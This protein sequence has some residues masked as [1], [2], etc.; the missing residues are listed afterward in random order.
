MTWRCPWPPARRTA[1]ARACLSPASSARYARTTA[2]FL[3]GRVRLPL[4]G[5]LPWTATILLHHQLLVYMSPPAAW[6]PSPRCATPLTGGG[7][8]VSGQ[9]CRVTFLRI[10][11]LIPLPRSRLQFLRVPNQLLALRLRLLLCNCHPSRRATQT[12]SPQQLMAPW[13]GRLTQSLVL[14]LLC[15]I[16]RQPG[17]LLRRSGV[18]HMSWRRLPKLRQVRNLTLCRRCRWGRWE[19]RQHWQLVF[20][21]PHPRPC[22]LAA[23]LLPWAPAHSSL[24][25]PAGHSQSHG[26]PL[27]AWWPRL[28]L[29]CACS[30]EL[31]SLS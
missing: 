12:R 16:C 11:R 23:R 24:L 5:G 15:C 13:G 3:T 29:R 8:M 26:P 1:R 4:R 31:Q 2:G 6:L 20:Q 19:G 27:P 9:S 25:S 22:T 17:L 10:H 14:Q 21:A 30:T 18:R 28:S 7:P